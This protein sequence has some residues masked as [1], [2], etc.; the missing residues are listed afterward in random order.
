LLQRARTY[1]S[2]RSPPLID[3]AWLAALDVTNRVVG[4]VG[5]L[6]GH[7]RAESLPACSDFQW[8]DC[9]ALRQRHPRLL[10]IGEAKT[11][12]AISMM[13]SL[14][15]KRHLGAGDQTTFT[16]PNGKKKERT[17][18]ARLPGGCESTLSAA[19]CDQDV[20]P[21]L[22]ALGGACETSGGAGPAD[23]DRTA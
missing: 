6:R 3:A 12:K 7:D 23:R 20:R 1:M 22:N 17:P 8:T 2:R 4:D 11:P 5:I 16:V 21:L 18:S 15:R 14:R 13:E 19:H 10:I 9:C